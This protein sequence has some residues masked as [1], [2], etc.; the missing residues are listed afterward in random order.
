MSVYFYE[1]VQ[2]LAV[3]LNS[4]WQLRTRMLGGVGRAGEMSALTRLGGIILLS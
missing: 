3:Q 4:L 2:Q 1:I